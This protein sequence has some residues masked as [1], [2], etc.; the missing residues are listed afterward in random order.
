MKAVDKGCSDDNLIGDFS[1]V[2]SLETVSGKCQDL[3][4]I[5]PQTVSKD[6]EV[7]FLDSRY[8]AFFDC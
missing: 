1:R 7:K 8:L 2:C 5:T 4:Y 6:C 3:K